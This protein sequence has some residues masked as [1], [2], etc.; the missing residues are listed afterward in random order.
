MIGELLVKNSLQV[1][2]THSIGHVTVRRVRKEVLALR[3]EGSLM[4]LIKMERTV[5]VTVVV[6]LFLDASVRNASL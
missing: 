6:H 2:R 1:R 5:K 3:G 4:R